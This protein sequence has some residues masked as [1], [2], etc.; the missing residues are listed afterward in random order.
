MTN[1]ARNTSEKNNY[2]STKIIYFLPFILLIPQQAAMAPWWP[3]R[4]SGPIIF[5]FFAAS[6]LLFLYV[7][8]I[9][10]DSKTI[11]L[12]LSQKI[13]FL[14]LLH[15]FISWALVIVGLRPSL[16]SVGARVYTAIPPY[17]LAFMVFLVI[18][19]NNWKIKE[20]ENLIKGLLIVSAIWSLESFI[21][22]Y[23][24]IKIPGLYSIYS[25]KYAGAINGQE[26]FSS[27]FTG[28]LHTISKA[29]L[30]A[31]WLSLYM[32]FSH[33]KS[34]YLLFAS[35]AFLTIISNLNRASSAVLVASLLFFVYM[36]FIRYSEGRT[37]RQHSF[38]ISRVF[39][40]V[41]GMLAVV[42]VV[43]G[44]IFINA[45]FK[46][47]LLS[48]SHGLFERAYQY[49]RAGEIIIQYPYG[50]GAGQG[51]L[52]CYSEDATQIYT[53]DLRNAEPFATFSKFYQSGILGA[54]LQQKNVG[55]D[56]I[57][58]IHNFTLNILMDY[59]IVAWIIVIAYILSLFKLLKFS[60]FLFR[61]KYHNLG[62]IFLCITLA[63][64][65]AFVAMQATYKFFA[66]MW[67]L[68][69]LFLFT[70]HIIASSIKV[71]KRQVES[72]GGVLIP[73]KEENLLTQI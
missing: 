63:Q 56:N 66:W 58:S 50:T 18:E 32:F 25:D 46:G 47:S 45:S 5:M 19:K 62:K 36:A 54:D 43:G 20:Y 51:F 23:L 52:L 72:N 73:V 71:Q 34:I 60:R 38:S 65:S 29:S 14:W 35:G 28:S 2:L 24:N 21:T 37:R 13:F 64:G 40:S 68:V 39:K 3:L 15:T 7:Y 17:F 16:E 22:W 8:E 57:Y 53:E 59:G 4:S 33:K 41:L 6:V 48:D 61:S 27:G 42:L 49:A 1:K 44:S 9:I 67:I 26:W 30:I 69:F 31:F 10:R 11:K 70:K 12:T 55:E